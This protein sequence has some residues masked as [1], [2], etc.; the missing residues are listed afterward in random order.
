VAADYI[1]ISNMNGERLPQEW[2]GKLRFSLHHPNTYT[3]LDAAAL[4]STTPLDLSNHLFAPDFVALSF[5]KIFG[6]PDLGALIVRKAAGHLFD[7]RKY[8]GGGVTEMTSCIGEEWVERKQSSLHVRLEDGTLA[9]RSILALKCAIAAHRKLFGGLR[10]VSE[11]TSWLARTLHTRLMNLKHFN[12]VQ[13]CHLYKAPRAAYGDKSTQGAT[14]AFNICKSNGAY[15]GPWH[16]GALL[17]AH[18]IHVRT[19]TVCNPAGVACALGIDSKWLRTAFDGGYRCNTE[20]D[21]L[22]GK[23]IGI[24]RVTLG[25]MSTMGDVETLISCLERNYMEQKNTLSADPICCIE[26]K[27]SVM[28]SEPPAAAEGLEVRIEDMRMEKKGY[29]SAGPHV[30]A[31][32]RWLML[33]NIWGSC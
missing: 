3:L 13:L 4:V 21:I 17:R 29:A 12:G 11:H 25:A 7:N 1:L 22:G 6:F 15:V 33:R 26:K 23:P 18:S 30:G 2:T 5:Y 28:E 27:D 24:V 14:V 8:F 19:G 20:V 16:V 10:E 31:S 32:H 9:I